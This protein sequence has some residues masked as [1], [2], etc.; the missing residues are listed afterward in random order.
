MNLSLESPRQLSERSG[1]PERRIRRLIA[2]N[3]IRHIRIGKHFLVPTGALE[4]FLAANM[5]NPEIG[6]SEAD[7]NGW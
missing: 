2:A 3:E 5:V 1:W 6:N 4:E 7:G